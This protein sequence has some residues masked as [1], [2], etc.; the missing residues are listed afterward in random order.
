MRPPCKQWPPP[1]PQADWPGPAAG[2][3]NRP[4]TIHAGAP[5]AAERS[6]IQGP[7]AGVRRTHRQAAYL[8]LPADRHVPG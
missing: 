8:L 6:S 1:T 5:P 2:G 3:S 7:V 4:I